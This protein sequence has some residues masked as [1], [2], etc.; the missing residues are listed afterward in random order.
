MSKISL[1]CDLSMSN[2]FE[3]SDLVGQIDRDAQA[4]VTAQLA[5]AFIA[6][7]EDGRLEPGA[8]LPPTRELAAAAGVNHLTAARVYKRLAEDGR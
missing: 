8:K 4:S 6:A 1:L 2:K 3:L 5:E 7:I